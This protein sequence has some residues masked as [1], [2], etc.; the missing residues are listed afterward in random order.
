MERKIHRERNG[1]DRKKAYVLK[2][3]EREREC[4]RE[5]CEMERES[6]RLRGEIKKLRKS[7]EERD[8][9]GKRIGSM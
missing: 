8:R 5:R 1:G 3:R 9:G 7:D 6:E 2:T 4:E